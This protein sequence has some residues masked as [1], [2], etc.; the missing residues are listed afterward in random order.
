[1]LIIRRELNRTSFHA[2]PTDG[3]IDKVTQIFVFCRPTSLAGL[4]RPTT[5]W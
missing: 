2:T 1:M 4:N 3:L 5:E